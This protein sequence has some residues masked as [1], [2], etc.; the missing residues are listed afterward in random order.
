MDWPALIF[1][2]E[3][4]RR[5]ESYAS[6]Q[7]GSTFSRDQ[8]LPGLLKAS[9]EFRWAVSLDARRLSGSKVSHLK[10]LPQRAQR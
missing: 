5:T 4:P 10:M 7:G 3:L 2:D 6:G 8:T 1:C 9:G